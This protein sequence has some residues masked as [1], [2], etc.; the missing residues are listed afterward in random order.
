VKLGKAVAN[1]DVLITTAAIPGKRAPRIIS[2]DMVEGMKAG[3]IVVDMACESGGN[4]MARSRVNRACRA[5][6]W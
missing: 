1:A 5:M 4:W 6:R 3:A 2:L